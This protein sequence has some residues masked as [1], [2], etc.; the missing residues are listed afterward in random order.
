MKE[1]HI[2]VTLEHLFATECRNRR[3]IIK[4]SADSVKSCKK[5][6]LLVLKHL[7]T[8]DLRMR[9]IVQKKLVLF[10]IPVQVLHVIGCVLMYPEMFHKYVASKE[11]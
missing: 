8:S 10:R 2:S 11:T 4:W 7:L 1:L 5:A 3:N 6:A 9:N